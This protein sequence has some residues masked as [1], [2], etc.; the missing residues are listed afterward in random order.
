[1]ISR[2]KYINRWALMRNTRDENLSEHCLNTAVIAHALAL[3]NNRFFGGSVN[4]ER[5][6][7]IGIYHDAPEII[8]GDMPTPVKYYNSQV[9]N[10]YE[11]V[12]KDACS[13]LLNMLPEELRADY[14]N[15]ISETDEDEYLIK[16]VKAADKLCALI[17][18]EEERQAGNHDFD[19]AAKSTRQ[20]LEK[21]NL[22]EINYFMEHFLDSFSLTLDELN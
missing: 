11:S 22:P 8:T 16:L 21:M 7:V 14:E 2:M 15:L 18:C 6:A 10:A 1:M 9:H 12:E 13:T 17:K 4:A 19:A 20:K 5:A 3:I